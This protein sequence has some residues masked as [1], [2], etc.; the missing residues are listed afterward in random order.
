MSSKLLKSIDDWIETHPYL[1]ELGNLHKVMV[2]ANEDFDSCRR[3]D[4][5]S[6][7]LESV[8]QEYVK[9]VPLLSVIEDTGT[10]TCVAG[11]LFIRIVADLV[12]AELPLK[13]TEQAR[14]VQSALKLHP[15]LAESL[16]EQIIKG[17]MQ[18]QCEELKSIKEGF[19]LFLAWNAL[20]VA[21]EPLKKEAIALLLEVPWRRGYC[22]VCGHMPAMGQLIRTKRGRE[23]E[24]I[25][26]CCK[27]KWT[28]RRIGCPS[29]GNDNVKTLKLIEFAEVPDMRLDTCEECKG[30]IKTYINEGNEQVI[31]A[32]WST[33]HLDIVG[34]NNGFQRVDNC[35]YEL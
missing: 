21:L 1:N 4:E 6:F 3:K 9:G 22:P 26:G 10:I 18:I 29:C 5:M 16:L 11:K 12:Q 14:L 32:D 34:K 20:T 28:Y 8:R 24:L 23:R 35:L 7:N 15:G 13:L 27:M 31:L 33:L 25:C 17:N 2:S 30:Y 19:V